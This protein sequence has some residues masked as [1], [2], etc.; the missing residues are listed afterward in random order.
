[1]SQL[2]FRVPA[3][4]GRS[5]RDCKTMGATEKDRRH[6]A[7]IAAAMAKK[8]EAQLAAEAQ[9]SVEERLR[10]GF[11]L[12]DSVLPSTIRMRRAGS[13]VDVGLA[14]RPTG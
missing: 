4:R 8:E 13:V 10:R 12:S 3:C 14:Q 5:A 11:A 6:F 9:L 2:R 1:M 7:A